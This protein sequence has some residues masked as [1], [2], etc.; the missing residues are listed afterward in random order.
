MIR[1]ITIKITLCE[2]GSAS[3]SSAI[4]GSSGARE[5]APPMLDEMEAASVFASAPP[6]VWDAALDQA[7]DVPLA[8]EISTAEDNIPPPGD[9]GDAA[10]ADDTITAPDPSAKGGR[11]AR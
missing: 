5:I 4:L 6:E 11:R 7:F 3:E 9:D 10:H 8:P 2:D 1:E